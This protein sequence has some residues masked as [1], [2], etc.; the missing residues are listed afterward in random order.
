M[1]YIYIYAEILLSHKRDG[2]PAIC[3]NMAGPSR[4]YTKWNKSNS[5]KPLLYDLLLFEIIKKELNLQKQSRTD[6][7]AKG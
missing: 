1:L 6:F 7:M 3:N 4:H 2:T 5:E